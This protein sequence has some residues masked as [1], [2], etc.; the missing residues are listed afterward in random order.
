MKHLLAGAALAA[1]CTTH[2]WAQSFEGG[3]KVVP[4]VGLTAKEYQCLG[5]GGGADPIAKCG[6]PAERVARA[7]DWLINFY[8]NPNAAPGLT[9]WVEAH[10]KA[11]PAIPR[12]KWVCS[13]NGVTREYN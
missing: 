6:I 7:M 9:P 5:F 12:N 4:E 8:H 2:V 13:Y 11:V 1:L 3:D 10:C